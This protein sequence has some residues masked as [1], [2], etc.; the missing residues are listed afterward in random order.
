MCARW[1]N[2]NKEGDARNGRRG[3]DGERAPRRSVVRLTL[4]ALVLSML[5]T[6]FAGV[7]SAAAATGGGGAEGITET[8]CSQIK[9]TYRGFPN[10]ENNTVTQVIA[11]N[12]VVISTETIVFEGPE[13]TD[14]TPINPPPRS[15]KIDAHAKWET[16]G[17]KGG[18]DHAAQRRCEAPSYTIEKQQMIPAR[19]PFTTEKILGVVGETVYYRVL[20]KNTG[21]VPLTFSNFSDAH[22]EAGTIAGGPGATPVEPGE[23]TVFTCSHLL[24]VPTEYTNTAGITGTP[25]P[26]QGKPIIEKSN[27]VVVRTLRREAEITCTHVTFMYSGFP[28][29]EGNTVTQFIFVDGVTVYTGEYVFNGPFG[30]DTVE[31]PV[32]VGP[33]KHQIDAHSK[34]NTNGYKSSYDIAAEIKCP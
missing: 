11:I 30:Q 12:G 10:A 4:A 28:N 21:N 34:W 17:V 29:A 2:R 15:V 33:G 32:V 7:S 20:V 24:T 16:N 8:T 26:G 13:F 22:C 5:V 14:T 9:W 3:I 1:L 23:T 27:K 25:P 19:G 6:A 31:I 18:F